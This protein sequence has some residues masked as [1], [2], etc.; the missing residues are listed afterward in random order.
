MKKIILFGLIGII[1]A[2]SA[3]AGLFDGLFGK[4]KEP[5]T[6]EEACNKDDITK[7]CP[8]IVL[9]AK[10]MQE[11]L[12][13]NISK[14]SKQCA[15][16]IKKSATAKIDSAK[17]AVSEKVES[18]KAKS[19][20]A[21]SESAAKSETSKAET[22]AKIDAAKSNAAEIKDAAKQTGKGLSDTANSL[23]SMF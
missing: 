3:N 21:K 22:Q 10:T 1:S 14:V 20:D 15:E 9:G 13:E 16:Y 12:T 7:I 8:E 11:C 6:L 18:V 4:K 17:T 23:K 5:A 19:G 2:T